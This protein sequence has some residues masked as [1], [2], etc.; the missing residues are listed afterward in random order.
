[1]GIG[2][3]AL[4]RAAFKGK[5][6]VFAGGRGEK[7]FPSLTPQTF[8]CMKVRHFRKVDCI[9]FTIPAKTLRSEVVGGLA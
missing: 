4:H 1:M 6:D 8:L 5:V 9:V 3:S 2:T 7:I